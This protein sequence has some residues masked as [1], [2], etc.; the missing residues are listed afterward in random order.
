MNSRPDFKEFKSLR[1]LV[2]ENSIG[3]KKMNLSIIIVNYN[4][5]GFLSQC[6]ASCYKADCRDAFEVIVVDNASS[7]DS[8]IIVERDFPQ[9]KL[10]KNK[11]NCGFAAA[12]NQGFKISQGRH[13]LFLNPDTVV[14][15]GTFEKMICFLDKNP[16]AG[17]AAPKLLYPDN[18]LQFSSRSF[19]NIRTILLKRTFFGKIFPKS[20]ILRDYL[21][22]D[23]NHNDIRAI[24]WALAACLMV[25]KDLFGKIGGFDEG[26]RLYFEDVDLC[27]RI[28]KAGY[29]IYYLPDAIVLHHHRRQ[30]AEKLNM[31]AILHIRSAIRF[32]NKFGWKF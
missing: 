27:Y 29:K 20:K 5:A 4:T 9:A 1:V 19:Y 11:K 15:P 31:K 2:S 32:F 16:D 26:Y 8:C 23:W 30:S 18:S 6:L 3:Q 7:D 28:D 24:D 13:I 10:I 21:M 17:A 25:R 12:N 22:A 14:N